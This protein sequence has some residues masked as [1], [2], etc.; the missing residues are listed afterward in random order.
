M[1]DQSVLLCAAGSI[2]LYASDGE[3]HF[4]KGGLAPARGT[5]RGMAG[6]R[7]GAAPHYRKPDR[8]MMPALYR[9]QRQLLPEISRF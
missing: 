3:S 5:G 1:M 2:P 9:L 4:S 6:M 8:S 7:R